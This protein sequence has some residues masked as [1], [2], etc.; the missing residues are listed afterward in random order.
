MKGCGEI[1][2][3]KCSDGK[4]LPFICPDDHLCEECIKEINDGEKENE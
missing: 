3:V 4:V 1:K 2:K